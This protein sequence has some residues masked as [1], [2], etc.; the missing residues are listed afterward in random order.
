MIKTLW[1]EQRTRPAQPTR[2]LLCDRGFLRRMLAGLVVMSPATRKGPSA[3]FAL[4][5]DCAVKP[6]LEERLRAYLHL[7]L[8]AQE[9][10]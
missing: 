7:K 3:G 10:Q 6:S 5:D 2:C 1:R 8:S 9:T 4:C